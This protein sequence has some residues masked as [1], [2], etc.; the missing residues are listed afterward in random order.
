MENL[1]ELLA[2]FAS[3]NKM[4]G[5]GAL[6]VALVVTRYVKEHGL[7]LDPNELLTKGGGQVAGLGRAPVQAI[8]KDY[9]INRVLA[10][11]G[12]R[13]SRGS[14][15]NMRNYVSFLNELNKRGLV[16][17]D[18]IEKW[19]IDR[20]HEYFAGKPFRLR[21]DPSKSLRAIVRDLLVQAQKR[22][23][24]NPGTTFAGTVL[25]HLVGA[26]L[27]LLMG[28][29]RIEHHSASTADEVSGRDADFLLED[30]AIHVTTAPGEALIRKCQENLDKG[31]RPLI[32]TL[33][34]IV[35]KELAEQK[36]IAE[37]IDV[38]EAEQF[39]AGNLY[40]LGKFAKARRET[41]AK[42][43]IARYNEIVAGC[44]TD[45]SLRIEGDK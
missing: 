19:W 3:K 26:K 4:R 33:K 9:G 10:E 31:L 30:V 35:A 1:E 25:Q 18:K 22:Q 34:E 42:D 27:D 11:E 12:G 14:V 17:L 29:G 24:E 21:F 28:K 45:P 5:K 20:V 32:I 6:C 44:E 41:T 13:T 39:I 23:A 40:E 8:L 2:A 16:D 37:R 38:F 7:P 36:G 15:G 43:L